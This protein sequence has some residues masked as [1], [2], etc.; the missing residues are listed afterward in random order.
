MATQADVLAEL[1]RRR[2]T[3]SAQQ[4][5]ALDELLRRNAEKPFLADVA[6]S[7]LPSTGRLI[8]DTAK[9]FTTGLPDTVRGIGGLAK[10]VAAVPFQGGAIG[11]NL[12][13][14]GALLS[15]RYGSLE[16]FEQTLRDDPAGFAADLS[17][18]LTGAGGAARGAATTGS[19][20]GRAGAAAAKVGTAIDPITQGVRAASAVGGPGVRAAGSFAAAG[21]GATT[22]SGTAPVR[23]GVT[24]N[25]KAFRQ[26]MRGKITDLDIVEHAR[27]GAQEIRRKRSSLYQSRLDSLPERKMRLEPVKAKMAELEEDFRVRRT[28]GSPAEAPTPANPQGRAEQK[29][30]VVLSEAAVGAQGRRDIASII[31]T[32]DNWEDTSVLGMDALKRQLD[33]FYSDSSQARA[34]VADLRGEVKKQLDTV[35]GYKQMTKD[36]AEATELINLIEKELSLNQQAGTSVRKLANALNQNNGFRRIVIEALDESGGTRLLEETAGSTFT[37]IAPRGIMRPITGG[38]IIGSAATGTLEALPALLLTSPRAV[39]E[40]LTSLA[41]VRK[42]A[43]RMAD[44]VPGAPNSF[45]YRGA[46]LAGQAQETLDLSHLTGQ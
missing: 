19:R 17:G 14:L 10:D 8:G 4:Q 27:Q 44:A 34:F 18:L 26:A 40:L 31:N 28:E 42:G 24:R 3:L 23:V 43:L 5:A 36:Y 22:G 33:D 20:L 25:T 35:P 9:A 16:A 39:G 45:V 2:D 21:L 30:R 46:T 12:E 1:E 38:A 41:G 11:P 7:L 29:S 32:V 37:D 13:G 15:E 6:D